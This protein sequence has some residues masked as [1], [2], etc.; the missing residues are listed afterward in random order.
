M[1]Q[2]DVER[3]EFSKR[4]NLVLVSKQCDHKSLAEL[5]EMLNISRTQIHNWRTGK[6]LPSM[7]FA[8]II[9]K[10]FNISFEWL[11]TGSGTMDGFLMRTPDE[12]ALISKY[13]D[14]SDE[15]K[16]KTISFIFTECVE[17]EISAIQKKANLEKQQTLKLIT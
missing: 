16:Q 7:N 17:Y 13:R 4:F 5:K 1:K 14:L 3:L 8:S 11:M 9:A 15:G 10:T 12:I 2:L 6:H